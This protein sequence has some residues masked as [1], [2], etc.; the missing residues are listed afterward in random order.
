MT[1]PVMVRSPR[2]LVR[3][4][5]LAVL[6][7][8]AGLVSALPAAAATTFT[9]TLVNQASGGCAAVPGGA[10]TSAL[11]LVAQTCDAS[12][13]QSFTFTPVSGSSDA[14][15]VGT[16]TS[17]SC[18]DISGASTSDNA[19]VIQYACHSAGNQ[20][21]RLQAVGTNVNVVAVGSG[22]CVALSG[23]NLVQLP[24][25]T[26]ADR[27]WRVPGF[28]SGGGTQD[29]PTRTVRVFL[30]RPSDVPY[31]QR[32]PDGIANVMR[33]AQRYY[34]Q[35]LGKTFRLNSVVVEV[36]VGEH[37]KSWYE[38]TPNGSDR[39]WWA[40]FNMQQ[41]LL[42]R[43]DLRAPD[44]RWL[45]VGEVIAEGQGAG[46]GGGG[47]WVIL[48][49]HDAD[50][51]AGLGGAMNR[52]YGGMVHELGHAFGLPDSSST[53]GTPMSASFYSYPNTHFN[54]SQKTAIL[55]GPYGTFL[56]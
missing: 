29:P 39:Y 11:Q 9:S 8:V 33:E 37:V 48:C 5:V 34:L 18:L 55:N 15:R 31:D 10:S 32:Y 38:N 28:T 44:S 23:A 56:F 25:S 52:W 43:L 12:A 46:G 50:G 30:L 7:L 41:E 6:G 20:Q 36:V 45:N 13:R 19:A 54:Q 42:R 51:A 26:S 2:R 27:V 24:C 47:G 49:Q 3:L 4:V 40:V 1:R 35:E 16:L 21:F 14:Y 22:K 17:G 53:D